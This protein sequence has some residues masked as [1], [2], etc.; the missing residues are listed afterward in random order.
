MSANT[1]EER[2]LLVRKQNRLVDGSYKLT[3]QALRVFALGVHK[4]RPGQTMVT[5][6][7]REFAELLEGRENTAGVY[8]DL[9]AV[10]KE[11]VKAP[12]SLPGEQRGDT[13]STWTETTLAA[14]AELRP[15]GT[16]QL[17]F[18]TKLMPYLEQLAGHYTFLELPVAM[19]MTSRHSF[20]LYEVARSWDNYRDKRT[21]KHR[22]IRFSLEDIYK[23]MGVEEG[24]YKLFGHFKSKVLNRA[25]LEIEEKSDLRF[26]RS[27]KDGYFDELKD[28]KKVASVRFTLDSEPIA[29]PAPASSGAVAPAS[30]PASSPRPKA[31]VGKAKRIPA[32]PKE[33][34]VDDPAPE[35]PFIAILPS[36]FQ[37]EQRRTKEPV[38]VV[39]A[40]LVL[41]AQARQRVQTLRLALEE[42]E[43]VRPVDLDVLK[44]RSA[45]LMHAQNE[46]H[47]LLTRDQQPPEPEDDPRV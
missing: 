8:A 42:A 39:T 9:R 26:R 20:R 6:T 2:T 22:G 21:G 7:A 44:T 16:F 24:E 10:A 47:E 23:V 1:S 11:I 41:E 30:A 37:E 19:S 27:K 40:R 29:L 35:L 18:S 34:P 31:P 14:S 36:E 4:L 38:E 17:E 5:F 12:V 46:L 32:A 33:I 25:C 45:E 15:D 43:K 13:V 28:G 3:L